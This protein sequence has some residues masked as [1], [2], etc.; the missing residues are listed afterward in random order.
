MLARNPESM[1]HTEFVG[2]K[3]GKACLKVS[4]MSTLNSKKWT[5]EYFVTEADQ[6]PKEWLESQKAAKED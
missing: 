4:T 2:L 3:D 5:E 1:R 6:L